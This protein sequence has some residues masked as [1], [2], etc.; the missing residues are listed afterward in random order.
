MNWNKL[1]DGFPKD[2]CNVLITLEE[3][4]V[5]S[6][7]DIT[8]VRNTYPANFTW[9]EDNYE[10]TW[11]DK[12]SVFFMTNEYERHWGDQNEY[13]ERIVAWMEYPRPYNL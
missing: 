1:E 7:G 2:T 6:N 11:Y 10:W 5:N 13:S 8:L 9:F 3:N 4:G 12:T